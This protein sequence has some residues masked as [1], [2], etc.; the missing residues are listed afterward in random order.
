M[1]IVSLHYLEQF[2]HFTVYLNLNIE[3]STQPW[4][5]VIGA[6][7]NVFKWIHIPYD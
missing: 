5:E 7:I 6:S 2:D 1:V 3:R 4:Q